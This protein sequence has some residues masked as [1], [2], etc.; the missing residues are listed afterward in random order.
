LSLNIKEGEQEVSI[1]WTEADG[2][3]TY[4]W[5]ADEAD[6][7]F[8]S[9]LLVIPSDNEGTDPSLTLTYT[10]IFDALGEAGVSEGQKVNLKWSV[11]AKSGSNTRL[12]TTPRLINFQRG[13]V[14][15]TVYV[16]ENT[17]SDYDVYLAGSFG[18][19]TGSDWQQPGTNPSLKLTKNSDGTYS[20]IL[21]IP[22]NQSFE[23]K[24][25][26]APSGGSSWGNG[27]RK[28]NGDGTGTDGLPN[29][30]F[31]Y[32]GTS[33]EIFQV[34]NSWEGFDY[35]YIAFKLQAPE[36]TPLDK[37]IFIAGQLS[38]LGV[39]PGDWQ[40]PGTN[41]RLK[42]TKD[43]SGQNYFIMFPRPENGTALNYKYFLS[44]TSSPVWDNGENG[45]DRNYSFNGTNPIA[46]DVVASWS[47]F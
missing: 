25:F 24:Y 37:D 4:E 35:P 8:S 41:P 38:N 31:T 18:F 11:R 12:A 27:E 21:G 1:Q 36:N 13:G 5:I 16:P 33:D 46:N 42:L 15:F 32:D 34:V 40:Q 19:L 26:I 6:G 14:S 20:I 22:V 44:S 10:Q 30:T 9:P 2:A 45:G 3:S 39:A 7:D 47:G 29:R 17:P 28:P 23:Y 43:G